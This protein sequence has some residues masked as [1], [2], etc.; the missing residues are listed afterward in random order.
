MRELIFEVTQEAD[1]GYWAECL[2]DTIVT[3][4]DTWDELRQNVREVVKAFFARSN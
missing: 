1:G 4:G 3:E 2:T